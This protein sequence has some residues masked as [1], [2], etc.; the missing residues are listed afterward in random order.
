MKP[1]CVLG[2][3]TTEKGMKIKKEML[4]WLEPLYDV[5]VV[6]HDGSQFELP[7]LLRAKELSF[8]HA[9]PV[10]YL[11]TR[12]AVNEYITTAATHRMWRKEFGEQRLKY[13]AIVNLTNHPTVV[14]PYIDKSYCHRY[15]GFIANAAAWHIAT[16]APTEERHDYESIWR[17]KQGVQHIGTLLQYEDTRIEEIRWHLRNNF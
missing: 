5:T 9:R 3:M 6:E 14:A 17:D 4:A 16:L 12:G 15:N 7:A 1:L 11:H 2:V 13:Q 10:L 8:I